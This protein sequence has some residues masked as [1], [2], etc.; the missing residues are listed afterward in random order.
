[1]VRFVSPPA[2]SVDADPVKYAPVGYSAAAA[3]ANVSD[4]RRATGWQ[5]NGFETA[6]HVSLTDGPFAEYPVDD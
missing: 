3:P 4:I 5:G 2:A 1:M 6:P